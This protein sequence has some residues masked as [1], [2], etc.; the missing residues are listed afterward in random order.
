MSKQVERLPRIASIRITT[1]CRLTMQ[2]IAGKKVG[3]VGVVV[4]GDLLL[5]CIKHNLDDAC[6]ACCSW[7]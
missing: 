6:Y 1:S 5:L 2:S 7:T 3:F 4:K